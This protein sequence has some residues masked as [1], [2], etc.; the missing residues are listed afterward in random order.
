MKE[1]K[2]KICIITGSRA[3]YGYLQSLIKSIH[4]ESNLIL[5]LI[6]TGTHLSKKH[7]LSFMQINKDGFKINNK[8]NLHLSSDNNLSISR[9]LGLGVIGFGK[10][11][12]DLK[13]DLIVVV[14]DR[15]EIF[16]A[17]SSAVI[18]KIP[19][20]HLHGGEITEGSYDNL[21]R[22]AITKM[23]HIHIT[24]NKIYK[25]RVVQLGEEPKNVYNFGSLWYD[26]MISLKLLSKTNFEKK[27]NFK[28]SQTVFLITFH[29]L[30]LEKNKSKI[31]FLN[32]LKALDNI[33]DVTLIFTKCNS[34]TEGEIINK[35]IDSYVSLNKDKSLSFKSM[36]QLLYYSALQHVDGV[37]GNSSSGLIE[38][39]SFKI[40]TLN[41]GNRQ[42]GRIKA[43]S[44]ID[45]NYSVRAIIR[46]IKKLNSHGFRKAIKNTVNPYE[47]K[48]A[49]KKI[50]SLIKKFPFTNIIIKK[51]HDL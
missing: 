42:K 30:T 51:F 5:Q 23:S 3:E 46:G 40:G 29:P 22:H 16:S 12:E 2:K 25:K 34:D 20:M 1:S 38:V 19:V 47:S 35:M 37:I 43:K 31:Y 7:G 15:Y 17:I 21:F 24:A 33:K 49:T 28:L 10:A 6:V 27:I 32:I 11:L 44:V 13:P 26:N 48:G 4:N 8:I 39:P 14:G 18:S 36:G 45:C 50:L 9:S 41:I